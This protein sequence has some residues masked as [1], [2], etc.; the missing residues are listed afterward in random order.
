RAADDVHELLGVRVV[1]LADAPA[2]LDDGQAHEAAG[3]AHRGRGEEG[4]EVTPA[5]AAGFR[6]AQVHDAWMLLGHDW[7]L[8]V[9]RCRRGVDGPASPRL[10]VR[11]PPSCGR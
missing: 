1:V 6:L 7:Y 11:K 8:R 9:G 5:P 4:P 2:G 10:T 3:G